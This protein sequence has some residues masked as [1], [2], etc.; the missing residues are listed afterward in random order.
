MTKQKTQNEPFALKKYSSQQ[1]KDA[2]RKMYL[3]RKFEEGAE[4]CYT[5]GLI[6]GTMHLSIGQETSAVGSR[7]LQMIRLPLL[8]EGTVIA[9]LRV[10]TFHECLLNFSVKKLVTYIT[11]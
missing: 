9:L 1:L 4:N 11:L 5:R 7:L 6:H 8:T 2:L 10:Q 3:I